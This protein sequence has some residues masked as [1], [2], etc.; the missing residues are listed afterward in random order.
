MECEY[1]NAGDE[2]YQRNTGVKETY[3]YTQCYFLNFIKE[4][5]KEPIGTFAFV[6]GPD[7]TYLKIYEG[8]WLNEDNNYYVIHRISSKP[9]GKGI[10]KEILKFCFSKTKNIRIDTHRD[11]KIMRHILEKEGFKYC[12]IIYLEDGAERLAYQKILN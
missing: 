4:L 12:G 7:S 8:K 1:V 11:N 3:K 6:L 10:M 5:D 9:K 2:Y